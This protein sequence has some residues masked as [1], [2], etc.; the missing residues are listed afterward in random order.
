MLG[1]DLWG[2]ILALFSTMIEWIVLKFILDELSELRKS[3]LALNSSLL[4]VIIIITTLTIIEFDIKVKLFICIFITYVLY[5]RNYV[6]D[7]WKSVLISLL[8]WMLLI[9][10]DSIG[11]SIVGTLNSIQDM[12]DL[13]DNNLLKVELMII[14]KSL[15]IGLIPLLKAIRL[16]IKI[17]KK[18]CIYLFFP[19]IANII[20]I[21]V[22]FGFIF[23]DKSIN[24]TESLTI[25]VISIVFLLSNISLV[26]IIGRIIK[27]NNLRIEHEITEEKMN[28]QYKYYLN[29]Q[30]YQLKTRKLYHDMSNHIICIQNIYGKNELADKYI[31]DIN[32]QIKECNTIFN[33]QSMILDVI[34]SEKKSICDMNDIDFLVDINFLECN[35]IE[36]ADVCS[37]FSNMIDNAIEACNK[38]YDTNIQKKI[39]LRGTIVNRLF[40]IKCE[41][42]KI[43][44]IILKN[45]KIITD[46]KDS[47]LHGIGINS[48]KSSVEKYN[49]NVEIYSEKNKFIITIYIPLVG[50]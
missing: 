37:I 50:K 6:V 40:V 44:E 36:M 11:L 22:V 9:G 45:N 27:D 29:L 13:L 38:I 18:D 5:R 31:K 2:I 7:K 16:K 12:S 4:T 43:N 30:E 46:K 39:K 14:S 26:S 17:N 28:I 20:S 19:L 48:I 10:F 35:F 32:K 3:K 1:I 25:L 24:P 41:N 23:K 21:I 47:F 33:T 49:G 15:L 42:T 34:L 8:Y